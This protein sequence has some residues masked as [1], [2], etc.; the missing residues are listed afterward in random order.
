MH[1]LLMSCQLFDYHTFISKPLLALL[2]ALLLV[3]NPQPVGACTYI[4]NFTTVW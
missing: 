2:N 3:V 4:F 1:F